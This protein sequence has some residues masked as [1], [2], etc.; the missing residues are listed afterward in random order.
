MARHWN[1]LSRNV[2]ESL[3]L[4]ACK[5]HLDMVLRGDYGGAG[6]MIGLNDLEGLFHPS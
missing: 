6:L 5:R 4:E 1:K 3:S 2:V